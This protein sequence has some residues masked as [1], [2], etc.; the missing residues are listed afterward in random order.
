MELGDHNGEEYR[1][2][3]ILKSEF[4]SILVNAKEKERTNEG[5]SEK[6]SVKFLKS[7]EKDSMLQI[8]EVR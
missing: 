4:Q 8:S 3:W 6:T 5:K 1:K 2:M 7:T